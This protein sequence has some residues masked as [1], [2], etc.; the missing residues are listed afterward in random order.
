[1]ALR[2]KYA[3]GL[4]MGGPATMAP[5][6]KYWFASSAPFDGGPTRGKWTGSLKFLHGS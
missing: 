2:E 4:V 1:V 5:W 6:S 3:V